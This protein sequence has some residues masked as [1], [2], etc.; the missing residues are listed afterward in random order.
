M[1]CM[2]HARFRLPI[3]LSASVLFALLPAT[4]ALAQ[5]AATPIPAPAREASDAV[6]PYLNA[7]Y[8]LETVD[9]QGIAKS[10]T[11]STLRLRAGARTAAWHGLSA[12]IEGDAILRVGP[13]DYNDTVN[14]RVAFPVVADPSD[15]LL[16]QAYVRWQPVRQ[17]E[18]IGG[19]QAI[20][21]DNQR[22]VG[23]VDWRQNDQTL[24]A[25]RIG[26]V[27]AAGTRIDYAYSW[28]VNRVFGKD[29]PQGIWPDS[30]IHLLRGSATLAPLGTLIAYGYWLDIPAVPALSSR[31]LG[32]RLTGEKPLSDGLRIHYAAEY[33]RQSDLNINP[34]QFTHEYLLL[35]SGVGIG[36]VTIRAGYE[37]LEGDGDTALQ[38]A[39][40]TLH[41]FNGWTDR[42][43][44]TPPSGLR[45]LYAD[46]QWRI[47]SLFINTPATL[48]F[49]LHD[50][51]ATHGGA[52]YGHEVGAW[53]TVPITRQISAAFKLSHY[54]ADAFATNTTKS[55]F[56]V[57]ARF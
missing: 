3:A 1:V 40:A 53:L 22:W 28:R 23:S 47:G 46:V 45:D 30:D 9:Q 48:R 49:Q 39:L 19:R 27:P 8:R 34:R 44:T 25:A 54:E 50:F 6:T 4:S 12:V 37:R 35:E 17:L 11:A 5:A 51:N 36:P 13:K 14:G 2:S 18:V 7:R 41:A 33:A 10:A 38:T 24:D 26:V 31:T 57:E 20:N 52:D 29:S 43:L 42:F 21:F 32:A 55:W 15:V 56:S 16:N